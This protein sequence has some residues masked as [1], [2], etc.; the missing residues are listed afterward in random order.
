MDIR[1]LRDY[2]VGPK[3]HVVIFSLGEVR[4]AASRLTSVCFFHTW[5]GSPGGSAI[6]EG[7]LLQWRGLKYMRWTQLP[8]LTQAI[9]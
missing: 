4:V 5:S 8:E 2:T 1:I 6:I 7:L 9:L 3:R